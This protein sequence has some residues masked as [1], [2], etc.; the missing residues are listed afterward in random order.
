MTIRPILIAPHPVLRKKAEKVAVFD[1]E[2]CTL[3]EDMLET[4]YDAPGIGLAAPQ[5]GVSQ[6]VLVMD[7]SDSSEDDPERGE[8]VVMIN[9]RVCAQSGDPEPYDEGCLSLPGHEIAVKRQC[10]VTIDYQDTQGQEHRATFDGLEARCAL[11]EIDHLQGVM[12]ID[13]T[14]QLSRSRILRELRNKNMKNA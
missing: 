10:H 12:I 3:V 5:I 9:P 6:Q 1:A 13:Y 8:P 4:M 11:H 2:L 14:S 7:C